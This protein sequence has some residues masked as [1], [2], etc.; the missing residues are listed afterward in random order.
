MTY[1][2]ETNERGE[3]HGQGIIEFAGGYRYEG[4]CKDGEPHGQGVAEYANG[5]R[6]E[7]QWKDGTWHG[8]GGDDE[9]N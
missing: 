2:G 1:T 5:D 3:K 8:Q 7:G 9:P 6:Y 4:Q